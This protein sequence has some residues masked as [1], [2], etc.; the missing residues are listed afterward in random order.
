[1]SSRW[2]QGV[3]AAAIALGLTAVE[4]TRSRPAMSAEYLQIGLGLFSLSVPIADLE[5]FAATGEVPDTLDTYIDYLSPQARSQLQEAL[6]RTVEISPLAISQ[7]TYSAL[8]EDFL[9][10][11][12]NVVQTPSG[13]N[14]NQ[15]MRA[16]LILAAADPEGF[17]ILKVLQ[18]F[19]TVGIHV[20]VGEL[21]ALEREM[22]TYFSYR[23]ASLA[24]IAAQSELEVAATSE[25]LSAEVP[26]LRQQGSV[27]F[28]QTTLTLNNQF[29]GIPAETPRRFEVDIYLPEPQAAAVPLVIISH[30]LGASR[31][32]F[33]AMAQ[34][35]ASYGFA[36]A[37]PDHPGS[38][39]N[40]QREFLANLAYEG[41][42]PLEFVYRPWDVKSI[43]DALAAD[44]IYAQ[45]LELNHVGVIGHSFGGYTALALGGAPLNQA[46]IEANCNP[47]EYVLNLSTLLQCRATEL[48]LTDYALTDDRVTAVMAYSP[49]TSVLLGPESVAQVQTPVMMVT[50]SSDFVAPAVPEQIHPFIWL[51]TGEKY[52]ATFLSASHVAING[53]VD[54]SDQVEVAPQVS[55][56]LTGPDPNLSTSYAHAL[57]V[58]FMG[59]YLSDR[60]EY[61]QFLGAAYAAE[62][63]SEPPV[64]LT[65]ISNLT[66]E[67][68]EAAF[69]DEPPIPI[70]PDPVSPELAEH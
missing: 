43:I 4:G 21:L 13:I 50:S 63:L 59:F 24:A 1:M 56:L 52:L 55:S 53:E 10:R 35:L 68:L 31:A 6:N 37:V 22:G 8:G 18:Y 61:E 14:G 17:S 66:A 26:D 20:D 45:V 64:A 33:A 7:M 12:G 5:T 36:V 47:V 28:N 39:T 11:L 70:Y 9:N 44:P 65:V 38:D 32:D 51:E 57:N 46:R 41:V 19:P 67:Q 62:F 16:A 23:D 54:F 29:A 69:G 34:H 48:P 3:L 15:A 42:D 25:G 30:G 58:A 49:V 60:P 27:A 40:Y 2:A